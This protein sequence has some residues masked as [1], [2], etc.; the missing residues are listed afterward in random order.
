[1]NLSANFTLHE[2]ARSAL[3]ARNGW[4]N[5]PPP[6]ALEYLRILCMDVLEPLR[7]A[8]DAPLIITSGYRC[9]LVNAA[10]C[11][12]DHSAH[13]DGRAAD[14]HC[15]GLSALELCRIAYSLALP[16][17]QIINEF[18]EWM[19]I[20]IPLI[21]VAPARQL[22]YTERTRTGIIYSRGLK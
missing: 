5:T 8:C 12:R 9:Q 17:T 7:A 1:M 14:L 21:G 4:D 13:M 22:L 3:A 15:A 11:G 6:E 10:T 16:V 18:G 19:H 20:S 2:L